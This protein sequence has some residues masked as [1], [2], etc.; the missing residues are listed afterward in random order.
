M[1]NLTLEIQNKIKLPPKPIL[2]L[3]KAKNMKLEK[4]VKQDQKNLNS[5]S[6]S[7]YKNRNLK[8]R[9]NNTNS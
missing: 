7:E 3:K 5:I 1:I 8:K 6:Y 9:K 2:E 4:N